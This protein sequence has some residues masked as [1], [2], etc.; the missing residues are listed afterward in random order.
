MILSSPD[1]LSGFALS[2]GGAATTREEMDAGAWDVKSRLISLFLVFAVVALYAPTISY[3][4][5]NYDDGAYIY[6]NEIVSKGLHF[7]GV[8]WALTHFQL[9]DW[10]PL[11][12]WSH[13][14]AFSLFDHWAGGHHLL[15]VLLHAVNSVLLFAALRALTKALWP[16]AWVAALFALH[17]LRVESV[18]WVTE[19]KDVLS[20]LF[21]LLVL[22]GY[23]R[24]VH[25]PCRKRMA[26]VALWLTLGLMSKAM[27]I[28]TPFVLLLLDIWPLQRWGRL[29]LRQLL[30]EKKGLF[31]LIL[32]TWAVGVLANEPS[33]KITANV[34]LPLRIENAVISYTAYL[35]DFLAPSGLAT[36]Y[37]FP[38]SLPWGEVA[39]A[40][41]VLT[42]LT[43]VA[44]AVA[45]RMPWVFVGWFWYLGM[46]APVIG[47]M[48]PGRFAR[49]DRYTYLSEIGICFAIVWSVALWVRNK[50]GAMRLACAVG[51]VFLF[52]GALATARQI[53]YWKNSDQLWER[54]LACTSHNQVALDNYLITLLEEKRYD[55]VIR[56]G[57]PALKSFPDDSRVHN[58]LGIAYHYLKRQD[59]ALPELREA[60]RLKPQ[61]VDF[62]GNLAREY[63][64]KGLPAEAVE[65]Y[66]AALSIKPDDQQ[67]K[68]A[69]EKAQ[70][71]AASPATSRTQRNGA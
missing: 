2:R 62:R 48:L 3:G 16:S 35:K 32:A 66:K 11:T 55:D 24:Y 43:L 52:G 60:V 67:L 13:M 6:D 9:A 63:M 14:L 30:W 37:P 64:G 71:L 54:S 29:P 39:V 28:T 51:V 5:V 49:A 7:P 15:N 58:S 42:V 18:A 65:Q 70:G 23:A 36:L 38:K 56:S 22:L 69:C 41:S 1:Q 45:R 8:G 10:V 59:D 46:L 53:P 17:P 44:L 27:L 50:P 31:A 57:V 21:F 20:G 26:L 33:R 47:L 12:A 4:F 40:L 68:S 19:R 25:Q 61:D 34:P